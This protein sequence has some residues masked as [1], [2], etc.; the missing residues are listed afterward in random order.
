MLQD[1]GKQSSDRERGLQ[2]SGIQE[3]KRKWGDSGKE[4]RH[5]RGMKFCALWEAQGRTQSQYSPCMALKTFHYLKL[6][7]KI[8]LHA[9]LGQACFHFGKNGTGIFQNGRRTNLLHDHPMV[10]AHTLFLFHVEMGSLH[11]QTFTS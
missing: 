5:V 7:D 1:A 6:S 3:E 2:A 11:P 10:S 8:V 4:G 9:L